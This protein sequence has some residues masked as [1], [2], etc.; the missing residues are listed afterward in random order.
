MK[1]ALLG[2]LAAFLA[3]AGLAF[4]QTPQSAPSS[5]P[6]AATA[7]ASV[8]TAPTAGATTPPLSPDRIATPVPD[9]MASPHPWNPPVVDSNRWPYINEPWRYTDRR[10]VPQ[11][12][13]WISAD[14]LLWGIKNERLPPL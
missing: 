2:S 6:A 14:Y 13:F 1:K 12:E 7:P 4:A 9:I 10:V 3:G 11:G 8:P 5:A